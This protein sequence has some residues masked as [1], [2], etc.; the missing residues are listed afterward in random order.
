MLQQ[1]HPKLAKHLTILGIDISIY[2]VKWFFTLFALDLRPEFVESIL[3]LYLYEQLAVLVRFSI[4][5]LTL[6]APKLIMCTDIDSVHQ[7]LR[8]PMNHLKD[9]HTKSSFFFIA[10]T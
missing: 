1:I 5:I 6:L 7:I 9:M 2:T 4:T 3:D 10:Y 8:R